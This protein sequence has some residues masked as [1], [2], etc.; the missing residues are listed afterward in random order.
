MQRPQQHTPGT[1]QL[2]MVVTP[3]QQVFP[4]LF[5]KLADLAT[6]RTLGHVQQL[7]SPGKTAGAAG[8]FEGFEGIETRHFA[9]HGGHS[10]AADKED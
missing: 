5:L 9:F 6:D 10:T 8:N 4:Q 3:L 2:Q 1:G 7:G